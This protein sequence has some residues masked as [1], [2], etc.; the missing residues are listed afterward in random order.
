MKTRFVLFGLAIGLFFWYGFLMKPNSSENHSPPTTEKILSNGWSD[1]LEI[2]EQ[3]FTQFDNKEDA[4]LAFEEEMHGR[5]VRFKGYMKQVEPHFA[6]G[7]DYYLTP[8]VESDCL[9]FYQ[10]LCCYCGSDDPE[11]MRVLFNG[12]GKD[13]K[14]FDILLKPHRNKFYKEKGKLAETVLDD[15]NYKVYTYDKAFELEANI[16]MCSIT[17]KSID[18]EDRYITVHLDSW[19]FLN[20]DKK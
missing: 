4:V 2:K 20:T 16:K 18:C 8:D 9:P 6:D 15:G 5:K 19:S 3:I 11:Y 17:C 10:S 7:R 12:G 14:D 13:D 1:I